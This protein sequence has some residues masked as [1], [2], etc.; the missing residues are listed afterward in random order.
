M[1]KLSRFLQKKWGKKNGKLAVT[2]VG[3]FCVWMFIGLWHGEMKYVV[4]ESL[5]YW[6]LLMLGEIFAKRCKKWK[7]TLGIT[8]DSFSW[9]LFQSLRT[10]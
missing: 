2:A 5:W 3:M 10:F 7:N 1:Q 4:G 8:E 6:I 9:H